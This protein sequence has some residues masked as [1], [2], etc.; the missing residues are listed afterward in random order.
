MLLVTEPVRISR[1]AGKPSSYSAQQD[2]FALSPDVSVLGIKMTFDAGAEIH[3]EGE[4]AEMLY[5]VVKGA[6]RV[7]NM[8]Y[9]GR[10][11]IEGFHLCGDIFGLDAGAAHHAS[12]EATVDDTVIIAIWR[13]ALD[14]IAMRDLNVARHVLQLV[15]TE[16]ARSRHHALLLGRKNALERIAGFLLDMEQRQGQ[17][18]FVA[19]PVGRIDIADYLGLTIET[20]SR[21]LTHLE[22]DHV[23]AMPTT[24][25]LRLINRDALRAMVA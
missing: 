18:G 2:H 14:E 22:R 3:G 5:R 8:R 24:R 19:L 13:S 4:P 21:S 9:D 7:F 6:V 1:G 11:Q 23:I 15:N 10:R 20:V 12:A 16:C 17:T 25:H